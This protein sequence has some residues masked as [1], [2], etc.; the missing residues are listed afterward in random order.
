M[1]TDLFQVMPALTDSEYDA[2]RENIANNGVLVPVVVD[3]HGRVLD[4]HHRRDIA[5]DLGI[6]VPTE[7]VVVDD[8]DHARQVARTLNLARRHLTRRQK[9]DLI[10]AELTSDPSRSNR[11]IGRLLGVDHKTVGSV[12]RE[13]AG[14]IP[15]DDED[16]VPSQA[17]LADRLYSMVAARVGDHGWGGAVQVA[18]VIRDWAHLPYPNMW[19]WPKLAAPMYSNEWPLD[20]WRTLNILVTPI[21]KLALEEADETRN[22]RNKA[23][24]TFPGETLARL[25]MTLWADH[26]TDDMVPAMFSALKSQL[27]MA[28]D[29]AESLFVEIG[30]SA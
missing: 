21:A 17:E 15:H 8:D 6:E 10:A 12:R 26:V 2:L 16:D 14:E 30:V 23:D 25:H 24:W 20:V 18:D 28:V 5:H 11:E 7:T 9:R 27:A 4:G 1:T 22:K 29:D 3:Q 19:W 13:L